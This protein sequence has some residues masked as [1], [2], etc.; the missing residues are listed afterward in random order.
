MKNQHP[1]FYLSTRCVD[2]PQ[3]AVKDLHDLYERDREIDFKTFAKHVDWKPVAEQMGH[4]VSSGK[5]PGLRLSR[6]PCVRFYRSV[7]KGQ[8][9][10]HMDHSSVDFIFLQRQQHVLHSNMWG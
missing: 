9:C 7:W 8:V 4:V 3:V 6:D 1:K 2:I 10:Y 5:R